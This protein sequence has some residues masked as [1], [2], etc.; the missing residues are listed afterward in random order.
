[1]LNKLFQS[2][3]K[4][5][6]HVS[7]ISRSPCADYN[8]SGPP[9]NLDK[10]YFIRSAKLLKSLQKKGATSEY[11]NKVNDDLRQGRFPLYADEIEQLTCNFNSVVYD[12]FRCSQ[13]ILS[14]RDK[15][16]I[17]RHLKKIH[18]EHRLK[19]IKSN[20]QYFEKENQELRSQLEK[21][22]TMLKS[23]KKCSEKKV[24]FNNELFWNRF[25]KNL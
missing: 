24:R 21:N 17:K 6:F 16:I 18:Y 25:Y 14:V 11:M 3:S 19:D 10:K 5:C 12:M 13:N 23:L 7:N 9:S 1:M 4:K 15:Q 8:F 20:I 2:I 22:T